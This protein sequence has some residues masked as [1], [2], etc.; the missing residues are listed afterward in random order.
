MSPRDTAPKDDLS[1]PDLGDDVYARAW[2]AMSKIQ[3][4]E[5]DKVPYVTIES[6]LGLVSTA[7][8]VLATYWP[9]LE[10]VRAAV[11]LTK[12]VIVTKADVRK[13]IAGLRLMQAD[14]L[15]SLFGLRD[16][17]DD[18][19]VFNGQT[20][21]GRLQ[22]LCDHIKNDVKQFGNVMENYVNENWLGRLLKEK[23]WKEA[24]AKCGELVEKRKK[25]VL[26]VMAFYTARR[27]DQLVASVDLSLAPISKIAIQV[28]AL[29]AL[30]V[31][32]PEEDRVL[33]EVDRLGGAAA[34]LQSEAKLNDLAAL[35][36]D[37][38][39]AA[40]R[41]GAK[42]KR[43]KL[44][45]A[46]L[47]RI[48]TPVEQLLEKNLAR[49]ES[50]IDF[51][52][53]K[54]K[55]ERHTFRLIRKLAG[56][57]PYERIENPDIRKLWKEMGWGGSIDSHTFVLNLYDYFI[58]L[59]LTPSITLEIPRAASPAPSDA[60]TEDHD[61]FEGCTTPAAAADDEWCLNYFN[62]STLST[63]MEV[64]DDDMNGLIK[65]KEVNDFTS[66]IPEGITLTQWIA[67]CAYGWLVAAHIYRLRLDFITEHMLEVD[68]AKENSQP[69]ATYLTSLRWIAPC[70]RSMGEPE[71]EDQRLL[72]VTHIVMRSQEQRLEGVLAVLHYDLEWEEARSILDYGFRGGPRAIGRIESRI[73]PVLFLIMQQHYRW[74]SL[75]QTHVI[76]ES[77]LERAAHTIDVVTDLVFERAARLRDNFAKQQS[78]VNS[79]IQYVANGMYNEAHIYL[80]APDNT[81]RISMIDKWCLR[82]I[83]S[84]RVPSALQE[85]DPE[86]WLDTSPNDRQLPESKA[87]RRLIVSASGVDEGYEQV[88]LYRAQYGITLVSGVAEACAPAE[89]M[90]HSNGGNDD[91]SDDLIVHDGIQCDGCMAY[92]V[93]GVRFKCIDC[94]DF[95]YCS[96]CYSTSPPPLK[97][98]AALEGHHGPSH[99]FLRI[100]RHGKGYVFDTINFALRETSL[101]LAHPEILSNLDPLIEHCLMA[102]LDVVDKLSGALKAFRKVCLEEPIDRDA[103]YAQA[104]D[105]L[106][107]EFAVLPAAAEW[108]MSKARLLYLMREDHKHAQ[109]RRGPDSPR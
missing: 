11:D 47:R 45:A 64:L 97:H 1:D 60:G 3:G 65:I 41:R 88:A 75:C 25:E 39:D 13:R 62:Y 51:L 61:E 63:F 95:D 22:V 109:E 20:F 87:V 69:V 31:P 77:V 10:A 99:R 33:Q 100:E 46:E 32:A 98:P 7:L 83:H 18:G 81:Q 68:F 17:K 16:F 19:L 67:Y 26:E 4:R 78:D 66:A 102:P 48:R 105:V 58:D 93:V 59:G 27:A 50:K 2:A 79:K 21:P 108:A 23:G 12:S 43:A 30:F 71:L 101:D 9:V 29:Q 38:E 70:L 49:F 5:L 24:I 89:D 96:I 34:C 82:W 6:A 91:T 74:L 52:V 94:Y 8:G 14:M 40:A 90:E 104:H 55:R 80:T 107:P 106:I 37:D 85:Y 54:A 28:E 44:S 42:D 73:F 72:K 92:P 57:R 15:C 53:D 76:E 103:E 35:M 36:P 56:A 84:V 86:F